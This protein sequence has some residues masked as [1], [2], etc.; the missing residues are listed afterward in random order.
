MSTVTTVTRH[1]FLTPGHNC[2][3]MWT[4]EGTQTYTNPGASH[5]VLESLA[6]VVDTMVEQGW[7]VAQIFV[8]AGTP[9]LVLL[10]RQEIVSE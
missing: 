2:W 3:S 1:A 10:R 6:F 7:E 9:S 4:S 5:R 8:D